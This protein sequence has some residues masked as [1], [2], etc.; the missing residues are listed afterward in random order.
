MAHQIVWRSNQLVA[1][2]TADFGEDVIAVGDLAFQVGGRDEALLI[3]E[4]IL[5][6]GYGLVV[7]HRLSRLA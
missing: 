1:A 2:E 4:G 3:G 5:T 7:T 6:L